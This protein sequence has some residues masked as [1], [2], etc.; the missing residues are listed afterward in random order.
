MAKSAKQEQFNDDELEGLGP[1]ELAALKADQ[2]DDNDEDEDLD[3]DIENDEGDDEDPD[4]DDPDGDDDGDD[5]PDADDPDGD[6]DGEEDKAK[7]GAEKD[8]DDDGKDDDEDEIQEPIV[9]KLP[10]F[11][12]DEKDVQTAQTELESIGTERK[13]LR[14][15]FRDGDIDEDEYHDQLE[16]LDEKRHKAQR[17]IDRAEDRKEHNEK[18]AAREWEI[19]QE[20]FYSMP[21]NKIF[22]DDPDART[23][24]QFKLDQA[25][26]NPANESRTNMGLLL[27]AAKEARKTM[28]KFAGKQ[29][30]D[31]PGKKNQTAAEKEIQRRR[32]KRNQVN[33]DLDKTLAGKTKAGKESQT[34]FSAKFDHLEN[35][36]GM[37]LEEALANMSEADQAEWA[38][39]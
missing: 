39:R 8:G 24:L 26:A 14:A 36:D 32:N 17:T 19:T 7:A 13:D 18:N 10:R 12:V 23:L 30:D 25:A 31:K 20:T 5:D 4:G 21:D 33:E 1:E 11:S 29:P 6:P 34:K 3:P 35:L 9:S 16:K 15:R 37:D 2:Q 22:Q 28:A 38:Q 27:I